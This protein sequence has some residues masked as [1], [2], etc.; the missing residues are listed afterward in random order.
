[1]ATTFTN[2][3]ALELRSRIVGWGIKMQSKLLAENSLD[4]QKRQQL[5]KID[6]NQIITG[7]LDSL[8]EKI[9]REYRQPGVAPPI[10]AD[11]FITSTL[12]F[13]EGL[14]GGNRYQDEEIENLLLK[15]FTEE[16]TRFGYNI[17]RKGDILYNLWERRH[18]DLV[19]WD[20]FVEENPDFSKIDDAHRAYSDAL[21]KKNLVDFCLLEYNLLKQFQSGM[22]LDFTES[23]KAVFVDE[24]QDTN[25]LQESIYFEFAKRVEGAITIVGDDDQSLYRFRGSAVEL[26]NDFENRY[27]SIFEEKPI[28][29]FLKNNY[30]SSGNIVDFVNNFANSDKDF[31]EVRVDEKPSLSCN[32]DLGFP[33]LAMTRD[34]INDLAEDLS[35]FIYQTFR[36]RGYNLPDGSIVL[37]SENGGDLGDCALLGSSPLEQKYDGKP[38]LPGLLRHKLGGMGIEVFNPRGQIL[39]HI[40]SVSQFGGLL[41]KCLDPEFIVSNTYASHLGN[42][43]LNVL[44]QWADKADRYLSNGASTGLKEYVQGWINRDPQR[45]GYRWPPSVPFIDL[46]YDLRH[47][48]PEFI[49]DPEG[50]LYMEVF[51]RQLSACA[52]ISPFEARFVHD[53]SKKEVSDRSVHDLLVNFLAPIASGT[54]KVNEDLVETFPRDRLSVLSIHQSKGLE[55]PLIIVDVGSDFRS[56]HPAHRFKR[57][58]NTGNIS[59]RFEDLL[60]KYSTM[61]ISERSRRDRAFDDLI[62]HYI[63]AYSRPENVL[64]LVGVKQT[65]PDGNAVNVAT[66]WVRDGSNNWKV[67]TPYINI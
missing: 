13:R 3:A 18:Q 61:G 1:L 67:N 41:V 24:Y 62:R 26:F 64:L 56:D 29:K 39:N 12:M 47:Y 50:Q 55:Y 16:K 9:S 59:H 53:R 34:N 28:K 49:N 48:F 54:I 5:E 63:V 7:T 35:K 40:D 44:H 10:M 30:R 6:I 66:G 15:L 22:Y 31:Q 17:S 2:K 46:I 58:P 21:A 65:F 25:L 38:R 23:L 37:K 20:Q 52:M 8:C 60:R 51:T 33:V 36:G 11:N 27:S 14:L 57:Y 42:D 19:N 43:V 45:S 32:H 4:A